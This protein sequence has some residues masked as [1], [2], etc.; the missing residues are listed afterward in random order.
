MAL[1]NSNNRTLSAG[2]KVALGSDAAEDIYKRDAAGL[3]V[4]VA[5]VADRLLGY[6]ASGVFGPLTAAAVIAFLNIKT[7][8][9]STVTGT[10]QTIVSGSGYVANSAT[11]ITFTLPPTAVLGDQVEVLGQGAGGWRIAQITGQ[12]I[13]YGDLTSTSG[14]TGYVESTH[15]KDAIILRAL[16]S[17]QWQVVS[18]VGILDVV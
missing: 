8:T 12:S 11:R 6:N 10:T 18:A 9:W 14:T 17:T 4:R 3:L 15:S 13:V 1:Q 16:S 5:A 2:T 7:V